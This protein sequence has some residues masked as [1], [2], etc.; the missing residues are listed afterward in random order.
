MNAENLQNGNNIQLK[1]DKK[2][3]EHTLYL[4]DVTADMTGTVS[5]EAE[6]VSCSA[7]LVV[8]Q[9]LK[10]TGKLKECNAVEG[11]DAVFEATVSTADAQ[12]EWLINGEQLCE[13]AEIVKDNGESSW[14]IIDSTTGIARDVDTGEVVDVPPQEVEI[15]PPKVAEAS[16]N[17]IQAAVDTATGKPKVDGNGN[18]VE[19]KAG[20]AVVE[21]AK[22]IKDD[23][24]TGYATI[25]T[26]TGVVKDCEIILQLEC[27][28]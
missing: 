27:D 1:T 6:G 23:G 13:V 11:E 12:V 4:D 3:F 26:K 5:V 2:G 15:I 22:I 28:Y 20:E 24:K 25:D 7:Q 9:D 18:V 16:S 14:A 21:V 17:I 8:S 19:A 10:F